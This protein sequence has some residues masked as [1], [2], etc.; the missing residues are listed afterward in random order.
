MQKYLKIINNVIQESVEY[1][2]N[3]IL[4]FLVIALPLVFMII[5]WRRI[6]EAE[7]IIGGYSRPMMIT[8]KFPEFGGK[9]YMK[10]E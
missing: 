8:Q 7:N 2:L 1:R 3:H 5:L 6:Y 10:I 4:S 9:R